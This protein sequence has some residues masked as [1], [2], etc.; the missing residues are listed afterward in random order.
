MIHPWVARRAAAL[1]CHSLRCISPVSWLHV[2]AFNFAT[3]L[4]PFGPTF[5]DDNQQD[6][7]KRPRG[8]TQKAMDPLSDPQGYLGT[9]NAFGFTKKNELFVG[10]VAMLVSMHTQSDEGYLRKLESM[11]LDMVSLLA[12]ELHFTSLP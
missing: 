12:A 11:N 2:Q 1:A 5:D 8:P 7:K 10:R 3:A 4:N 6:V 9:S